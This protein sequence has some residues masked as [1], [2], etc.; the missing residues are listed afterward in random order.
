MNAFGT[1]VAAGERGET[2]RGE[3]GIREGKGVRGGSKRGGKYGESRQVE[4]DS[5][6]QK[7]SK[8]GRI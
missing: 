3:R 8:T 1:M 7:I 5:Q 6:R 2:Y 4:T